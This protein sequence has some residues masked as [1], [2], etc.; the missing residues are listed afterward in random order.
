MSPE[1]L[2]KLIDGSFYTEMGKKIARDALA[3]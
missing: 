1:R 2:A 3:G